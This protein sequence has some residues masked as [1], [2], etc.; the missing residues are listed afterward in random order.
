VAL[1]LKFGLVPELSLGTVAVL[2]LPVIGVVLK[3]REF[4]RSS[5]LF[6]TVILT[7]EAL[8]GLTGTL[9]NAGTVPSL[10][11][12]D[13]ALVGSDFTADVQNQ[14]LSPSVT[15]VATIFYGLHV[16]LIIVALGLFWFRNKLAYRGY[17]YSMIVVSYLALVTFVV[18]PTAP[19]WFVGP[20]KNL[21]TS[22]VQMLPGT[23]QSIQ[24]ALLSGES[25]EFAAFPSL[26]AAYATLFT[27][28]MFKLGRRYGLVS[29]PILGG[30]YF[31]IIYLGQHYLVDLLAGIAYSAVS[32]YLVEWFIS[33]RQK[34]TLAE[35]EISNNGEPPHGQG[36]AR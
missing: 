6:V 17:T 8:Q 36:P 20:A 26:H 3:S 14:F 28:Y 9:V 22:G 33:R 13:K 7:Y 32:I 27:A 31:S 19:P 2:S 35:A 4:V 10:A 21:L 18:L 29:L 16:F 11:W 1:Y 25:D 24:H 34:T 5:I 23:L 15:Y 30:V 12:M